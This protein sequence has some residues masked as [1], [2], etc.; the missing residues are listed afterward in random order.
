MPGVWLT[1]P[2][3]IAEHYTGIESPAPASGVASG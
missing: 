1:T 3:E 2:G